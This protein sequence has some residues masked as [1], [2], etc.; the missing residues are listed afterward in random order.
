MKSARKT[1]KP[2][3]KE[4]EV[5]ARLADRGRDVSRFFTNT[6]R[7][8]PGPISIKREGSR[9]PTHLPT[10]LKERDEWAPGDQNLTSGR[11]ER[12]ETS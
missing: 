11:G 9:Q 8:M 7:V 3:P 5:I 10:H 6:G 12:R 1:R 4:A 2:K